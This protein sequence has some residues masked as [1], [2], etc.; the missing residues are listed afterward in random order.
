[1]VVFGKF[2][3]SNLLKP[4]AFQL[5]TVK[6][7]LLKSSGYEGNL[8]FY[9]NYLAVHVETHLLPARQARPLV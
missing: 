7:A 9:I 5:L 8:K 2:V 6:T 3:C 1:M 4:R